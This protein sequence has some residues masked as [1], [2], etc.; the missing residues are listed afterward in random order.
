MVTDEHTQRLLGLYSAYKEH[1]GT[2]AGVL[3]YEDAARHVLAPQP[4]IRATHNLS[5]KRL[6]FLI[7]P[8]DGAISTPGLMD[9]S[10]DLSE[11]RQTMRL[12]AACLV[13]PVIPPPSTLPVLLE[14][15]LKGPP[16]QVPTG[17]AEGAGAAA[18]GEDESMG[19][20]EEKGQGQP[21]QTKKRAHPG[22]P[23]AAAAA[24]AKKVKTEAAA[25][26]AGAESK[27]GGE[28]ETKEK[29]T[30][31]AVRAQL[32]QMIVNRPE[33]HAVA[34]QQEDACAD[35]SCRRQHM[36]RA[37]AFLKRNLLAS[38]PSVLARRKAERAAALA[39]SSSSSGGRKAVKKEKSKDKDAKGP[40]ETWFSWKKN[41][42]EMKIS[43]GQ[44]IW[45]VPGTA[46]FFVQ[47]RKGDRISTPVEELKA[48]CARKPPGVALGVS[49]EEPEAPL[50]SPGGGAAAAKK[51]PRARRGSAQAK[52]KAQPT[53]AAAGASAETLEGPLR[54]AQSL[55]EWV[56]Q[57]LEN[58]PEEGVV[59]R[60]MQRTERMWRFAPETAGETTGSLDVTGPLGGPGVGIGAAAAGGA[61]SSS[62]SSSAVNGA[63]SSSSAQ[64]FPTLMR[65]TKS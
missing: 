19:V 58:V 41:G 4:L 55:R 36:K 13:N 40:R 37:P 8:Y 63:V 17:A 15:V 9:T 60:S 53:A 6:E 12:I 22:D 3:Q 62:S 5:L 30:L 48:A 18:E 16:P 21:G 46:D 26:A 54:R 2:K 42:L 11:T 20:G 31:R 51:A 59:P 10:K 14:Q 39:G 23:P 47:F 45:Y 29:R 34:V 64:G 49:S 38:L 7:E 28:K 56:E 1:Q 24:G 57:R 33:T 32:R 25:A 27:E 35:E 43:K 65:L 52:A 50:S 44:Q 61:S